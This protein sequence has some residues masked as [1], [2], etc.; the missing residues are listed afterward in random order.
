[1]DTLINK[2]HPTKNPTH[3]QST[4]PIRNIWSHNH[5]NADE[6]S[7]VMV[8]TVSII[9]TRFSPLFS[10][11]FSS[12][13]ILYYAYLPCLLLRCL[14]DVDDLI[15]SIT[16]TTT[17]ASKSA[18]GPPSIINNIFV[19]SNALFHLPI[20]IF[21]FCCCFRILLRSVNSSWCG[22]QKWE[23]YRKRM[24]E[25][26]TT[27]SLLRR[28]LFPSLKNPPSLFRVNTFFSPLFYKKKKIVLFTVVSK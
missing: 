1:V 15:S 14:Y 21:Y 28:Q 10:S 2:I 6:D 20:T 7:T 24:R 3:T 11:F 13:H 18:I 27:K 5:R 4:T 25:R 26:V 23:S 19:Q 16:S 12:L 22:P 8:T 17:R 9:G